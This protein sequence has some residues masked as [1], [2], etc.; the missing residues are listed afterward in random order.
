MARN[1]TGILAF[2]ASII[3]TV[4]IYI[5]KKKQETERKE[6]EDSYYPPFPTE[7]VNILNACKLCFLAT[8]NQSEPHICTMNFT[9]CLDEELLILCTRRDTKKY[10]QIMNSSNVAVLLHDF[11]HL[12]NLT[13]EATEAHGRTLSITLNGRVTVCRKGA[14]FIFLFFASY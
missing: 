7:V 6:N 12:S 11:P 5:H 9:Y 3:P 13:E 1:F 14:I 2:V 8:A 4:F 10:K